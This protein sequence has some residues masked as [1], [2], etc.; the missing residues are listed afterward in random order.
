MYFNHPLKSLLQQSDLSGMI[1]KWVVQLGQF[2]I[3]YLPKKAIGGQISANFMAEFVGVRQEVALQIHPQTESLFSFWTLF[4]H[5]SANF[6]GL[7]IGVVLLSSQRQ[8]MEKIVRL[9]FN[10]SNNKAE[11]EALLAELRLAVHMEAET[12]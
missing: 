5:G 6:H 1:T 3:Q 10:A 9:G 11:Y 7:G 2:D 8:V 12:V 4:I